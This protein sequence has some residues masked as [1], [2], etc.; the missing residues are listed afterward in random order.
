MAK[1][2]P[3]NCKTLETESRLCRNGMEEADINYAWVTILVCILCILLFH[4]FII[5][6]QSRRFERYDH[7]FLQIWL[8]CT[9][10]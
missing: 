1:D 4:P 5:F 8:I 3:D 7:F 2:T 6:V 9:Y 10:L